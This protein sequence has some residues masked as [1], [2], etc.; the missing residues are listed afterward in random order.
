MLRPQ[1]PA[2]FGFSYYSVA[3]FFVGPPNETRPFMMAVAF[4]V[5]PPKETRPFMMAVAFF[6]GP[7][8]ETRPFMMAVAFFVGPPKETRHFMMAV[9]RSL[10]VSLI[11]PW[12]SPSALPRGRCSTLPAH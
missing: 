3:S 4:F 5:G 10:L 11:C 9:A 7:P 2:C 8:K 6:V 1:V 12:P